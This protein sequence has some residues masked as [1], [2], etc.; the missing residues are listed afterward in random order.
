[1]Q[2]YVGCGW[3]TK[4]TIKMRIFK[5]AQIKK[6]LNHVAAG[7][8]SLSQFTEMLNKDAYS[9]LAKRG[10]LVTMM[11]I[12]RTLEAFLVHNDETCKSELKVKIQ[13]LISFIQS[14]VIN[15]AKSHLT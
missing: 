3:A 4:K 15:G 5:E 2:C 13:T 12:V 1:M 11:D 6:M 8:M 9:A 7:N 10:E 14:Q